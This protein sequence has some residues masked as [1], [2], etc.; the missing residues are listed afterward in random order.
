M[1]VLFFIESLRAGGKERRIVELL[2]GLKKYPDVEVE[3]VLT[4]KE[5]HYQEFYDL[6][7]PLHVIERKFLKKDP[8]LFIKFFKI[9]RRFQ[10]DLIHVWGHMVAV[11]AVPT[12]W[13]LNVPLL[14]NE[15]TDATPG[16]KLLGKEIVFNASAKIIANTQ[17]GLKAYNAPSEKSGVIY[18]GFNFS[19]LSQ[20]PPPEEIRMKFKIA[21]PYVIA[22][23]A[24]FSEY[25]D[26]KT[27][28]K[29]A[30]DV[31]TKRQDVTF[32]CIGEGDDSAFKA[33]VPAEYSENIRFLGRQNKV[34]SIMNICDIGVLATDVR[35]H[36]EGISNALMEFMAL[37]KPVIATNFGGSVEL[38]VDSKTGFLVEPYDHLQLASRLL[39]LIQDDSLRLQ[40][41]KESNQRVHEQFSI[42]KMVTSF[43]QEYK[44]LT[45]EVL[46]G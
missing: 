24:T 29:A 6:N 43:Y 4:R 27:Y 40:M 42:E 26:Y 1:K 17:A 37:S 35:N 36:A 20:L 38:V 45:E 9:A 11:Y 12:V 14:N 23:V 33:M 7:I 41:G 19:R 15:I 39:D 25:K 32:L 5:I 16:Q 44:R 3:L 21:T 18:N 8:L 34:E 31:L 22:M 30:L 13:K 46:V 10:P 28:V 2:K